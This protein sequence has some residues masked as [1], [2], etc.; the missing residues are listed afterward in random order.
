MAVSGFSIIVHNG[1]CV[2]RER[3]AFVLGI[4]ESICGLVSFGP[5]G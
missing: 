4:H 3:L 1:L 5:L 2:L